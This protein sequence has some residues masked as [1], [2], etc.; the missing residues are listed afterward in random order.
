MKNRNTK[1][2]AKRFLSAALVLVMTL[3]L[4]AGVLPVID[5]AYAA[6]EFKYASP[7]SKT[8]YSSYYHKDKYAGNLIVNGVDISDWQSKKC[9]FGDA[10]KDGVDFVIM[11]VTYSSYSKKALSMHNDEKFATLYANSKAAGLMRGVYVFSQA[12]NAAEGAAEATFA[13]NRLK[14]LGIGPADLCLPVYMDYEF[15]GGILGRMRGISK[16]NATNAAVAFCNTVKDAGYTP[17]IYANT[18]FFGSYIATQQLASDVDLWCAQYNKRNQSGVNYSKWQYSSSARIDGMLSFTGLQ[19]KIDANFWYI[20]KN[21]ASSS[22][23]TKIRGRTTLS[24]KAA[25]AP[26]F[27]VYAGKKRLT[28]GKDYIVGGIRNKTRGKGYAYIKGIGNY[29]GYALIPI[30]IAKKSK[31]STKKLI[32]CAN[33]L[34]TANT[35]RSSYLPTAANITYTVGNSYVIQDYL[36]IR[37]G[38]G[39]TYDKV[40]RSDLTAAMQKKTDADSK[41]AILMPGQKVKCLGISGDW[42]KVSGGWICCRQGDDLYVR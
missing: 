23:V 10:K 38:A 22:V 28:E 33:Y 4:M 31:G 6:T 21:K 39:T 9:R 7:F 36:N 40:L 16:T 1:K 2:K 26:K 34:R 41:Y 11:R 14:A 25:K 18:T 30:K 27:K 8:G 20:N 3:S 12:K 15:A 5:P 24:K 29:S 42:M 35:E 37:K 13:I 32:S 17:G 19:G